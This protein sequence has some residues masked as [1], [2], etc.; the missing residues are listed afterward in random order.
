M[1]KIA[2]LHA[3]GS[4]TLTAI[5]TAAG[6]TTLQISAP[7]AYSI[8][9]NISPVGPRFRD[10]TLQ[11]ATFTLPEN[12]TLNASLLLALNATAP[13]QNGNVTIAAVNATSSSFEVRVSAPTAYTIAF[14]ISDGALTT[15]RSITFPR[16]QGT[17][18]FTLPDDTR[19]SPAL[20]FALKEA[21]VIKS[22]AITVSEI[23]SGTGA[24][25]LKFTSGTYTYHVMIRTSET[26]P[27]LQRIFKVNGRTVRMLDG[28]LQIQSTATVPINTVLNNELLAA[29][30][31]ISPFHQGK[32][33]TIA[34]VTTPAGGTLRL[35]ISTSPA[36]AIT[37]AIRDNGLE[38]KDIALQGSKFTLPA[39]TTFSVNL[40]KALNKIAP[41]QRGDVTI[42]AITPSTGLLTLQVSAPAAYTSVFTISNTGVTLRDITLRDTTFTLPANATFNV[43]LFAALDKTSSFYQGGTINITAISTAN[44]QLKLTTRSTISGTTNT[45]TLDLVY[46]TSASRLLRIVRAAT[47]SPA[48]APYRRIE[49]VSGNSRAIRIFSKI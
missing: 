18:T 10:I 27:V 15:F 35:Q 46:N 41:L 26:T 3:G 20:L 6:A 11:G 14:N 13:L 43:K 16:T 31:Q 47:T 32:S 21:S 24:L 39:N 37:F 19:F 23:T 9:F 5:V 34:S 2:P 1:D 12:Q 36:Y 30:D 33:M 25:T 22:G 29:L 4:A 48:A 40:L 45:R 28:S 17:A 38:F 42:A 8:A 49:T 44:G 7:I